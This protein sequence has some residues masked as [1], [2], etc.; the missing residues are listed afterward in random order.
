MECIVRKVREG[1]KKIREDDGRFSL[2]YFF[3]YIKRKGRNQSR[4]IPTDSP[5]NI[6]KG[7]PRALL[8]RVMLDGPG[9]DPALFS[10][11][12]FAVHPG[13]AELDGGDGKEHLEAL[14][15]SGLG[16]G[17]GEFIEG[18]GADPGVVWWRSRGGG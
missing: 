17:H 14:A 13:P 16:K 6:C 3:F 2:D 1:E 8:A 4:M 9:S 10:C 15:A 7:S 5:H 18:R 12:L 11:G